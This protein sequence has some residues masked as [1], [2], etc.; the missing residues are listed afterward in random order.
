MPLGIQRVLFYFLNRNKNSNPHYNYESESISSEPMEDI[1]LLHG[2]LGSKKLFEP[3]IEILKDEFNCHAINFSGHGKTRFTDEFSI[4][5]F[6][7]EINEYILKHSLQ[8]PIVF[9]HSMGGYAALYASATGSK[10]IQKIIT[11]GT[12]FDWNPESSIK[13]A[14]ALDTDLLKEK[15]PE[16]VQQLIDLHGDS[17]Q[18]LLDKVRYMM[19][20]LGDNPALTEELMSFIP[21]PVILGRGEKDRMVSLGETVE[22]QNKIPGAVFVSLAETRH[23]LEHIEPVV[24]ADFI[25]SAL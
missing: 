15:A 14:A 13:E 21:I 23:R 2:A 16:F 10:A 17:W 3:L 18:I 11:L 20:E 9:G 4:P 25:R 8:N 12:K 22:T 24:L 5:Q 19:L 7:A 1:I 6:A